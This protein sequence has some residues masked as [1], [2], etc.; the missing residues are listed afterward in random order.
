MDKLEIWLS[1]ST[2]LKMISWN[3]HGLGSKVKQGVG[4]QMLKRHGPD[5]VFLRDA[6]WGHRLPSAG[7]GELHFAGACR[8]D[9]AAIISD[10]VKRSTRFATE[11]IWW[12]LSI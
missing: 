6:S 3:V 10:L 11:Q 2:N 7:K 9:I 1:S 12:D 8:F 5:V 4:M